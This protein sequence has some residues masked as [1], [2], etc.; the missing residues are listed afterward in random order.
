MASVTASRR[1]L[2]LLVDD[3]P[4]NLHLLAEILRDAYRIKTTT[5]GVEALELAYSEP[6]PD[7]ILLD[8]MMPDLSGIDVLHRLRA[9][10]TT[11]DI[12]VIFVSADATERTQLIGLDDG[13]D[14]YL[15]KPVHPLVLQVRVRN[16]LRLRQAETE[17]RIAAIVF[18]SHESMV[19]TDANA[20]ILKVNSAFTESTGYAAE[21]VI[22]KNP[23]I[24][25]SDRHDTDF[26]RGMWETL[27]CTGTW[28]GEIWDRRKDGTIYPKW[29]TISAVKSGRG[30]VTN[31]VGI[32]Y[33]ITERKKTEEKINHLAFFDQLTGLPNRTL[34]LD[35][36]KQAMAASDRNST[37]GALLFI[38]LDKFKTLNDT[39][40]HD[41]G[42]LLLQQVAQRLTHCVRAGDTVARLGGDEF[43]LLLP[44]L[45][46]NIKEAL[47]QAETVGNKILSELNQTYQLRDLAYHST[48]SIGI[49]IFLDRNVPIDDLM[50]QADMAMYKSKAMGRNMVRFF[51]PEMEAAVMKR[52]ALEEDLWCAL[53]E[54][55]FLLHY[56]AQVTAE[57]EVTGVEALV[58]WSHPQR[59]MVSPADFIP[60]A[61]ETG[62]ILPLG[63]WVL[64]TACTQLARW[65]KVPGMDHL[66]IAINVSAH[67]FQ[68]SDF[69]AQVLTILC[70]AGANPKRL[71]LE[72]TES[73][74]VSDVEEIIAK[75][76]ALKS[77]GISFSLDDFGTGYSSLAYLKR[78]PLDQLKIDRSFV[79]DVLT[80]P[81][82]A[83]ITQ[84]IVALAKGLGLGVIAEGVETEGQWAF[85]AAA[86]CKAYQGYLFS[87]PLP[88]DAFESFARSRQLS[89]RRANTD[90]TRHA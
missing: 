66:T 69:V 26:Y 43:V 74:L 76:G 70:D 16:L 9:N 61:E 46:V 86:G 81:N 19:I 55:Q 12:P 82:D 17:R 57:G 33:D 29:L 60:L 25:K 79:R 50:K 80:D 72:L 83:A 24:F 75:M 1:P 89:N 59:G 37:Y 4:A 36:I 44:D 47:T 32:Q 49:T 2:L 52:A 20:V 21:E 31:Y 28:Q 88:L 7:L 3:E 15:V 34:L 39:L 64:E 14:D 84:T 27:R 8:V 10:P 51:D 73:I 22:G 45:G 5:K 11:S 71:K 87:R 35:R 48:A 53:E 62:L 58:R 6:H 40:G 68:R 65:A 23:R 18:D 38:D 90:G 78:M 56:Q 30:T 63:R 13:A 77:E 85:L 42:D 41:V 54:K 67:Q